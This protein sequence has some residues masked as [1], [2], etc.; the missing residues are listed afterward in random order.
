[1]SYQFSVCKD[2]MKK[3]E[4]WLLKELQSISTGR[5]N[6]ALLDSVMVE[7]Y[8]SFQ[9]IK[10][11]AS[12][13]VEEARVLRVVPWDKGQIKDIE[14]ALNA[15]G[16]PFSISVDQAGVRA[17]IPQLTTENKQSLTKLIKQKMEEARV[18]VRMERQKTDKD[19]DARE[20][21]GDYAEDA[22]MRA[23]D[24]LQKIV[25]ETNRALEAIADKKIEDITSV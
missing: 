3:I 18:S 2:E 25:D 20:K 10:N 9:P 6:P 14:K 19:I 13:S 8:G 22:K 16:L 17:S 21:A 24:D 4:E 1:M 23:K 7:S 11:I 12:I 5:A 15:S